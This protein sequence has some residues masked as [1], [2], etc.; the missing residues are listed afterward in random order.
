MT[1]TN[2]NMFHIDG[3]NFVCRNRTKH[4]GGGIYIKSNYSVKTGLGLTIVGEFWSILIEAKSNNHR[5]IVG[6]IYRVPGTNTSTSIERNDDIL[7]QL[8]SEKYDVYLHTD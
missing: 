8:E 2:D 4:R 5:F 3:Y 1:T 6:K 7:E